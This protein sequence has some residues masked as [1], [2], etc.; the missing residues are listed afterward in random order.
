M[1][2]L[3]KYMTQDKYLDA[4]SVICLAGR[5]DDEADENMLLGYP[6]FYGWFCGTVSF[7]ES[8]TRDM[9]KNPSYSMNNA[10]YLRRRENKSLYQSTFQINNVI[11]MLFEAREKAEANAEETVERIRALKIQSLQKTRRRLRK[12]S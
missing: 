10:E 5:G 4:A 1:R 7:S 6:S 9:D 8:I 3:D 2:L 11:K 12:T